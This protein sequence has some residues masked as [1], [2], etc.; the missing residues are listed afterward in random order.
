MRVYMAVMAT[1]LACYASTR[2][3]LG[4]AMGY[5]DHF[6]TMGW[7]NFALMLSQAFQIMDIVA[8]RLCLVFKGK[9]TKTFT[10]TYY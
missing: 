8:R 9:E 6:L 10:M 4:S 1:I 5:E 3:I 2:C 7:R